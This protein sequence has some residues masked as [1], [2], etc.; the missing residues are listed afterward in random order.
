[1][2]MTYLSPSYTV[3][4]P[5]MIHR[6]SSRFEP[7]GKIEVHRDASKWKKENQASIRCLMMLL[8]RLHYSST[9]PLRLL[10]AALRFTAVELRMLTMPPRSNTVPVRFKPV[11]LGS[12]T[13]SH[14]C[15]RFSGSHVTV[16]GGGGRYSQFFFIRRLRPSIYRSPQ[17]SIRNFKHPKK[18]E[19]LATKNPLSVP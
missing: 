19:I 8:R 9:D 7:D 4:I 5:A 12:I 16:L 11:A 2:G 15:A 6:D 1:M 10:T 14:E 18:F 13:T 17:K 3:T